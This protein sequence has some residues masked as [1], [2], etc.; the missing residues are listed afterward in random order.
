M[1]YVGDTFV[2]KDG[3]NAAFT[4]LVQKINGVPAMV[5]VIDV[6]G[7]PLA[8][9]NPLPITAPSNL[10]VAVQG[11]A[12]VSIAGTVA[13]DQIVY[14]AMLSQG[15]VASLTT[16]QP[17][18]TAT[19]GRKVIYISNGGTAGIWVA[20]GATPAVV[21]TGLYLPPGS[22]EPFPYAGE[23]RVVSASGTAGPIGY[24]EF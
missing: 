19:V 5:M 20:F 2:G 23:V 14:G 4:W 18:K 1:A 24:V 21:G 17:L 10:P 6:N 16:S 15:T 7:S 12:A 22:N 3:Q 13:T 8:T 11:T 9:A